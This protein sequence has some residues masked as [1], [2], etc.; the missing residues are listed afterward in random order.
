[1]TSSKFWVN[2]YL[3]EIFTVSK[4]PYFWCTTKIKVATNLEN[5]GNLKNCQKLG[6][7]WIFVEE[8]WKTQR[9]WK[10]CDTITNKNAFHRIFLSWVAQGKILKCPGNLRENSG[11]LVPQ[12]CGHPVKFSVLIFQNVIKIQLFKL[13]KICLGWYVGNHVG[14]RLSAL[15]PVFLQDK[16]TN[17]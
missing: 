8:T 5:S 11:N 7:F 3:F 6:E 15:L 10:I 16:I 1:M 12:K 13:K 9:K 14:G 4:D 2:G 17:V